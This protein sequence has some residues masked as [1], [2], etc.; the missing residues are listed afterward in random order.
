MRNVKDIIE[1][2]FNG[3]L[4][5]EDALVLLE[6]RNQEVKE[7]ADMYSYFKSEKE[8]E[9]SQLKADYPEGYKGYEF[10]VRQGRTILS[11][12]NIEEWR[13]YDQMK[14][15]CEK[16]YKGFLDSAMAGADIDVELPE[17]SYAKNSVIVKKSKNTQL[18]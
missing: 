13:H 11:Y 3:N 18:V 15:D 4:S 5:L 8:S 6:Q 12:N 17:V 9:I 2:H 14:K 7:E 10:E 1:D 16:R